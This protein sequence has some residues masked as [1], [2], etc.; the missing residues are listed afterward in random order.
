[1]RRLCITLLCGLVAVPA[2][3]AGVRAVGDGTLELQSATGTFSV[4]GTRG[5]LWGQMDKGKIVATDVV[6]GDGSVLVSGCTTKYSPS[7]APNITICTGKNLH[8][9]VKTGKY[10]LWMKGSGVDLTAVG[11]GTATLVASADPALDDPGAYELDGVKW[12]PVPENPRTVTFGDSG[13]TP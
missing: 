7:D 2:A 10:R 3:V 12:I 4:T 1:M 6:A 11:V 9:R 5:T 13:T 8:F